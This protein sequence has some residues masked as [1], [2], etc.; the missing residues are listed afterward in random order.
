MIFGSNN[1]INR[2]KWVEKTLK[3]IPTNKKIIDVGAG[4]CQYKIYCHHLDYTSQDFNQYSGVGNGVGYQT[5]EWDVSQIDIVSDILEIPVDDN[6]F[7][8][9]LCTEVL[10][11]VPN[12]IAAIEEMSRILNENGQIILTAPFCS[13]THF[14]PYHYCDGFSKYFYEYH[15]ER[16]GFKDIQIIPN[17][18]YYQ[19]IAQ[20]MERLPT[21]FKMFSNKS[22]LLLKIISRIMIKVLQYYNNRSSNT[23]SMLCFGYHVKATKT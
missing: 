20:E 12:P 14:A 17:G 19:Y 3:A 23:E 9:V 16:L 7:E 4:E 8:V 6:S 18:N 13:L 1:L 11:H 22:S 5:G 10:E 21:M 2:Q 15:L